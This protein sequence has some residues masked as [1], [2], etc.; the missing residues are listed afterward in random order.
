MAEAN[1]T[2]SKVEIQGELGGRQKDLDAQISHIARFVDDLISHKISIENANRHLE[3]MA[4]AEKDSAKKNKYYYAI[5]ENIELL[6]KIFNSI[7]DLENIKY[8]YN[9]EI[10]DVIAN[11]IK[12]IAIDIR[13]IDDKIGDGSGDLVAFFEKLSSV[14]SNP[15]KVTTNTA[16]VLENDPEYKM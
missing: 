13:R 4:M 14:M 3:Q 11:K 1:E 6:T 9:K 16:A 12:I 5:R 10:D 8:R 15:N 7:S 2:I